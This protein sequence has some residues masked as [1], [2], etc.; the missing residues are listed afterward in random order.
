MNL[1]LIAVSLLFAGTASAQSFWIP[2][3]KFDKHTDRAMEG[4][5]IVDDATNKQVYLLVDGQQVRIKIGFDDNLMRFLDEHPVFKVCALTANYDSGVTNTVRS[6]HPDHTNSEEYSLRAEN[7]TTLCSEPASINADN[8]QTAGLKVISPSQGVVKLRGVSF[9]GAEGQGVTGESSKLD[10]YE[11][12]RALGYLWSDGGITS[13]GDFLF[14]RKENTSISRH[15]GSVAES[16]FGDALT[17]NFQGN[18]YKLKLDGVTPA[19]FLAEGVNL[20][21]IPDARAFLTSVV[22][23]EGAVRVGR[24]TDDPSRERCG[25]LKV[26]VDDLNPQCDANTCT[27]SSC[28]VP[29]CAFIAHGTKRGIRDRPGVNSHCGVYLSGNASDWRA[30]FSNDDYHFVKT[31]RTPGGEPIKH[32]P[33]SRPAYTQ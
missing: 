10:D 27:G 2:A 26:L 3:E 4:A 28:N 23:A 24:L 17:E 15:F 32:D 21:D 9:R 29:N 19:E 1:I 30:L 16:F 8:L 31:D 25:Y 20:S 13:D 12:S 22:E 5:L 11:Y 14:F 33:S 6:K 18:R 7:Y